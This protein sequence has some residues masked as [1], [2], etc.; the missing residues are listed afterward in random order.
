ME[1]ALR[2]PYHLGPIQKS[3]KVAYLAHLADKEI[4]DWTLR[5]PYPYK[6]EDADW[7]LNHVAQETDRVGKVV[8]FA[9]RDAKLLIGGCGFNDYAPGSHRAEIGYWI[10]KPY[11]GKG[12]MPLA[13]EAVARYGFET[14]GLIRIT[15]TIFEKNSQSARVLE[16]CGFTYEGFLKNYY[17]KNGRAIHAKMYSLCPQ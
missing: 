10:A 14:L 2:S 15:A 9:L 6:A 16:K 8:N 7:W 4:Y 3:D 1:I 17:L 11:W 13:V 5:I 12:I